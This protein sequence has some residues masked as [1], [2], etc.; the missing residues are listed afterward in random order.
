MPMVVVFPAPL[1]PTTIMTR[2][3]PPD[4]GAQCTD[5]EGDVGGDADE[6]AALQRAIALSIADDVVVE[7]GEF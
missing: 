4:Q 1:T 5:A 3:V 6:R 7:E 2:G